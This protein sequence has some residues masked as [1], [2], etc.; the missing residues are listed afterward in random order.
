MRASACEHYSHHH[1]EDD[2]DDRH[3]SQ[4]NHRDNDDNND[5]DDDDGDANYDDVQVLR[6]AVHQG[7][8]ARVCCCRRPH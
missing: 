6:P 1:H 8:S 3:H 2:R 5:D 4:L 7:C